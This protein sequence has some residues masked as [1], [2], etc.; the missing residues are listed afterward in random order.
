MFLLVLLCAAGLYGQSLRVLSE[1]RRVDAKGAIL[2]SDQEGKPREILSP[3]LMRNTFYSMRIVVDP[4][5]GKWFQFEVVQNPV[6]LGITLYRELPG[7]FGR[8]EKIEKPIHKI[9]E[10]L[11]VYWLDLWVPPRA[12]VRRIRIEAQMHDGEGWRIAPMEV[13]ILKGI[14]PQLPRTGAKLPSWQ[15]S[16]EAPARQ[17]LNEFVCDEP[18]PPALPGLTV[19]GLV[20]RNAL[21]DVALA[22]ALQL[23]WGKT[24]LQEAIVQAA[25]GSDAAT[26]CATPKHNSPYGP[27]WYLRVR[28]FLYREASR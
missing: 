27:E 13:R 2:P 10:H 7:T 5:R 14:A 4:P 21:Q 16:A 26:W 6:G 24:K 25:G 1:F 17:A 3:G 23:H 22:R 18:K 11:E 8:L 15:E 28:D 9:G 20:R 19:S 12:L